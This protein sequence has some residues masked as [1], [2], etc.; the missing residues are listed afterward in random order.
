MSF[1]TSSPVVN[2]HAGIDVATSVRTH[3][4][5]NAPNRTI[6]RRKDVAQAIRANV[7]I[8]PLRLARIFRR[9]AVVLAFLDLH[10]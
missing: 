10:N 7:R 6:A 4:L 5:A 8:H 3:L 2:A 9:G 1:A